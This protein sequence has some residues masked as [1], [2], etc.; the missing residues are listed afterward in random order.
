MVTS[1][2]EPKWRFKIIT[3]DH[4]HWEAEKSNIN[5]HGEKDVYENCKGGLFALLPL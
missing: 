5:R 4:I 2:T 3:Q 1:T